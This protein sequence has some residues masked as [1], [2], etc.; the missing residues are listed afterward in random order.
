V[1]WSLETFTSSDSGELDRFYRNASGGLLLKVL[2]LDKEHKETESLSQLY[3]RHGFKRSYESFSLKHKGLL[4]AMLIVNKSDPGISLSDFLNGIKII[5]N[6][7]TGLPWEALSAAISQLA[8]SFTIDK[9]PVLVYPSSYME[10]KEVP[11]EK[12]YNLWILDVYY[13]K[14]YGEYMMGDT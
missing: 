4:K 14:E 6:D 13:G 8:G 12:K 9:I 5:V 3:A 2:R 1:E 7:T 11:F 10:S